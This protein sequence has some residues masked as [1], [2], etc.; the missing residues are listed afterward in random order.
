MPFDQASGFQWDALIPAEANQMVSLLGFALDVTPTA[1]EEVSAIQLF[2][3]RALGTGDT[4]LLF[5]ER[6]G[7]HVRQ[8]RPVALHI[9]AS[10]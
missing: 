2:R 5:R 8:E 10:P 9:D 6:R 1:G 7:I 4:T 3:F